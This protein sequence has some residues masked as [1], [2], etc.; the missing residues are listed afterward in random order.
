MVWS[1]AIALH[2]GLLLLDLHKRHEQNTKAIKSY[3]KDANDMP[4]LRELSVVSV[5]Q[6][7]GSYDGF[8]T[9]VV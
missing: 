8:Q 7:D 6:A 4:L 3:G 5:V 1:R 9:K 2:D